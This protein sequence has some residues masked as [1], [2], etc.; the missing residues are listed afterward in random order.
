M[1]ILAV[2]LVPVVVRIA[3]IALLLLLLLRSQRVH[4]SIHIIR[5]GLQIRYRLVNGISIGTVAI[6]QFQSMI[7]GALQRHSC[8]IIRHLVQ[9]IVKQ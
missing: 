7:N 2:I 9:A 6:E 5:G 3:S 4:G 1:P 8:G